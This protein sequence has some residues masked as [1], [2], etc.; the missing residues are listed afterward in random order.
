MKM[1]NQKKRQKKMSYLGYS[2][3]THNLLARIDPELRLS[4][5]A[6]IATDKII[7]HILKTYGENGANLNRTHGIS[8]LKPKTIMAV[9]RMVLPRFADHINYSIEYQMMD[10]L[11]Q[12]KALTIKRS[13]AAKARIAAKKGM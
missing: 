2:R 1:D 7:H 10:Y 9:N 4:Q 5:N 13:E 6:K 12:Q 3:Y 8:T 11:K